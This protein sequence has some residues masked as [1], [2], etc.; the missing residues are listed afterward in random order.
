VDI[1]AKKQ[2]QFRFDEDFYQNINQL[3]E[4]EGLTVSELVRNSLKLY[5]VF[6]ERTKGRNVK[7]F[8]EY[9]DSDKN[10]KC[11]LVLPWIV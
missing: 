11:E 3:A 7:I 2:A 9:N 10:E 1:M 8:L 4:S 5:K 6:Y